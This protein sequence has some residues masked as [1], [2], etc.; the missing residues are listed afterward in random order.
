MKFEII[1]RFSYIV[2]MNI[3]SKATIAT[4]QLRVIYDKSESLAQG[5]LHPA[6]KEFE[7]IVVDS[8]NTSEN[9]EDQ[10]SLYPELFY[11]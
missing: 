8:K 3:N 2:N 9:V 6:A 11:G 4:S 1:S 7:E 5:R 10:I